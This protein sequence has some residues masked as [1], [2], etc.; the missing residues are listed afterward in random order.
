MLKAKLSVRKKNCY[1]IEFHHLL[2]EAFS[3][4]KMFQ[5]NRISS[6]EDTVRV[7]I[8]GQRPDDETAK[9]KK[10]PLQQNRIV[11][12]KYTLITF[13]PQNMFE[14]F[15]R[16]ANFYFLVMTIIALVIGEL[17]DFTSIH[18]FENIVE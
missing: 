14:Q 11:S 6:A 7:Y 2:M 12:T 17:N 8:G 3:I 18:T 16:I 9:P 5:G 4:D 1:H 10:L 13:L 15:R